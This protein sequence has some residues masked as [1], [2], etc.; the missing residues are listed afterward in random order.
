[1][2]LETTH[3][4]P[5]AGSCIYIVLYLAN[6]D[7]WYDTRICDYWDRRAW[8]WK[9]LDMERFIRIPVDYSLFRNMLQ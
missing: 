3:Q 9:I 8:S 2:V 4:R 7:T 1:M 5:N 6:Q